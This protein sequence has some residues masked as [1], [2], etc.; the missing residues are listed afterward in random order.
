MRPLAPADAAACDAI[1]RALPEWFGLEEGRADCAHAVRS[2]EGLVAVAAE[3]VMGFLTVVQPFAESAEISWMAVHPAQRGRRLGRRLVEALVELLEARG[4]RLL[5][6]KT[7]S[8]RHPSPE[9][10]ATR[11]FYRGRGFLPAQELDIWGPQNPCLLMAR[12][13]AP[14]R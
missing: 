6:V 12:P 5:L 2:Q 4:V 7:L 9:Y 8:S 13:L 3:E 11:A 14:G 10:A 1:V